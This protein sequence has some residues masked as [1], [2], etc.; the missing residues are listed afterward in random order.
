MC[1]ICKIF[2]NNILAQY[3]RIRSKCLLFTHKT[4]NFLDFNTNTSSSI[5]V[6]H[7]YLSLTDTHTNPP[8]WDPMKIIVFDFMYTQHYFHLPLAWITLSLWHIILLSTFPLNTQRG[9]LLQIC[10]IW[11]YSLSQLE[12]FY[13]FL[14]PKNEFWLL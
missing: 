10:F 9:N 3:S 11:S 5:V 6:T 2:N 7:T 13:L 4:D 12:L 8:H 1:F 14:M